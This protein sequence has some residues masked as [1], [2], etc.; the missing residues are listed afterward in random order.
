[1][2]PFASPPLPRLPQRDA[3]RRAAAC[4]RPHAAQRK[5][6]RPSQHLQIA[7]FNQSPDRFIEHAGL[8]YKLS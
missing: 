1:M 7:A 2:R 4:E 5:N 8:T 6:V 3:L